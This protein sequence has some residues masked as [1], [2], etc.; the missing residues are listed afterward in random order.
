MSDEQRSR[1]KAELNGGEQDRP[2]RRILIP[3]DNSELCHAGMEWAIEMASEWDGTL[4][5]NHVYAGRLHDDRF[6]QLEVGLPARFQTP[7]EIDKQRKIHDKLIEQGL[8]LISDSFLDILD[9]KGA[10]AGVRTE[11]KLMEG[12]HFEQ[13]AK[14]VNANQYDLVVMGAHGIGQVKLSQLG[15][16]TDRVSR[17]ITA[18]LLVMK[19]QGRSLRGGKI[20]VA[21]DGSAYS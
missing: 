15:S 3:S 13:L 18:D 5:G 2:Y 1:E 16:V 11:R 6:R 10:R 12:I 9:K 21:V 19:E 8:I 20:V 14:D 7:R 17:L 4:V